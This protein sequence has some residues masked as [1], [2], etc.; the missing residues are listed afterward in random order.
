M[1][2]YSYEKSFDLTDKGFLGCILRIAILEFKDT[3]WE[4]SLLCALPQEAASWDSCV[5]QDARHQ[6]FWNVVPVLSLSSCDLAGTM[7]LDGYVG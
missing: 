2:Q 5:E 6:K 7:L 4:S 3:L 1:S